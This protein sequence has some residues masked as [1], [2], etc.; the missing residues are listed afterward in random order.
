MLLLLLTLFLMVGRVCMDENV[1][2]L[3][4]LRKHVFKD[5][6]K[7]WF[8]YIDKLLHRTVVL[9]LGEY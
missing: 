4:I 5:A 1:I 8:A 3:S 7:N 6:P 2:K 9:M